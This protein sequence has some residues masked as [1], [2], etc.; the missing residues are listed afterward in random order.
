MPN[1]SAFNTNADDLRTLIF[2]KDGTTSRA[3]A[4]DSNAQLLVGGATI[5]SGTL[6]AV[7][8]ATIAGGTLDALSGATITTGTLAAV[9]G[10][11]VTTGTL[12]AVQSAT[13]AGGTLD[14]LSGATI[15][16]GTLAAVL[17][18]TITAGTLSAVQ[19]ATIAGGTL[20]SVTSISQKSFLEIPNTSVVTGDNFTPLAMVNTSVL[21]TY[22]FFIYNAGPGS[23]TVDAQVEIS[24]N[25]T[26]WFVDV[27]TASPISVG[28]VDVLVPKRF[29]KYTRLSYKSTTSGQPTTIDVFFNAQGT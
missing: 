19:S 14:A 16:T 1:F 2:G 22:S 6:T 4:V 27:S 10:T 23:N 17:G 18:T 28:S 25:G 3:L 26:N 8:S 9:L 15:T 7:Q 21:G 5:T 12:A 20:D 13:I 29:L 11:T 24:A